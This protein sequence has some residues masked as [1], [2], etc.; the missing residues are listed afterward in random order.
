MMKNEIHG[1]IVERNFF[2]Q[3]RDYFDYF[4]HQAVLASKEPAGV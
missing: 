2:N 4:H 1:Q 3:R